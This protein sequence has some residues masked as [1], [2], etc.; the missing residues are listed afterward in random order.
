MILAMA[1]AGLGDVE[2]F[3]FLDPPDR[4]QVRDGIRLL[5]ELGRARRAGAAHA[6]SA[7]GSPSCRSIRGSAG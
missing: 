3:P 2:D 1:A 6:R 4:R 5:Q 7:A